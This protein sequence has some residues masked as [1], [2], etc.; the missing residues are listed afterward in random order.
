MMTSPKEQ[1]CYQVSD[2][3][4]LFIKGGWLVDK[5]NRPLPFVNEENK[6]Y[7]G[8]GWIPLLPL[9]PWL[10]R[11]KIPPW[12]IGLTKWSLH[13]FSLSQNFQVAL[14]LF[15][16]L[17]C[18]IHFPLFSEFLKTLGNLWS[19]QDGLQI[20][21]ESFIKTPCISHFGFFHFLNFFMLL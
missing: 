18:P 3:D 1:W 9:S 20:Q 13:T 7:G 5:R 15:S 12:Q 14:F 10:W 21:T 8:G 2:Y 19:L 4:I 17:N 16:H 6:G 11:S